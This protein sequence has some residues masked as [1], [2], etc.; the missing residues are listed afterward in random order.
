MN[1]FIVR[2]TPYSLLLRDFDDVSDDIVR[3]TR[4]VRTGLERVRHRQEFEE[5]DA[6]RRQRDHADSA[7]RLVAMNNPSWG[8][9]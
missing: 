8:T 4:V 2:H 3:I 1:N 9:F 5:Q 7:Q 6:M